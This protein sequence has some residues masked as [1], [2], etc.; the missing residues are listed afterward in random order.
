[1]AGLVDNS[2]NQS[3]YYDQRWSKFEYANA[4]ALE[5]CIFFLNA[6]LELELQQPRICDFGCGAGWL[7][8][9][10]SSF[11]SVVGVDLSPKAVEQ[12][13]DWYPRAQ[14]ECADGTNW[15]PEPESF[16]VFVS[17]EV[18]EHIEDKQ[19]YLRVIYSGLKPGG[20]L[21]MS[22]PN[23]DVLNAVSVE[24]R[25]TIWEIQPVE[26]PL[27]RRQLNAIMRE[28][29]FHVL[30]GGSVVTGCGKH[31]IH[32]I[33]NSHKLNQLIR[34][35]GLGKVWQSFLCDSGYGMYLTTVAQKI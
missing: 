7:T 29:G 13:R 14:F 31:G 4:Y 12:A 11:G 5:R 33:V 35:I 32:R 23:L 30:R 6:L 2:N 34:R 28:S 16:D 21:L 8:G 26:L 27:N 9:I 3:A 10:L 18:I 15:V 17:Q 24:E 20:Y 25:K 1:M 19:A 22:T